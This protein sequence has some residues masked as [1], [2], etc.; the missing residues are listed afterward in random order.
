MAVEN[1]IYNSIHNDNKKE[2]KQNRNKYRLET[3]AY[4]LDRI[5]IKVQNL[6]Y[7]PEANEVIVPEDDIQYDIQNA[8]IDESIEVPERVKEDAM[9]NPED[10]LLEMEGE[11][12]AKL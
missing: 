1:L 7:N 6:R 9:P 5:S 3:N 11:N 4:D 12:V 2:A 10:L 8:E